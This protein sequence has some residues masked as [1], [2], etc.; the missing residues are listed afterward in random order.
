MS[1]RLFNDN[2][3]ETPNEAGRKWQNE[4]SDTIRLMVREAVEGGFSLRDL[5]T[6]V[7]EEMS[8]TCAEERLWKGVKERAVKFPKSKA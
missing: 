8:V 4:I 2:G 7:I 5:Q 6:L 1:T 3:C